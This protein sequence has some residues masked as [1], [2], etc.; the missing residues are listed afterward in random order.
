MEKEIIEKLKGILGED[1]TLAEASAWLE[2]EENARRLKEEAQ[3]E[4]ENQVN[5]FS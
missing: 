2:V 4:I 5:N 3:T 1:A